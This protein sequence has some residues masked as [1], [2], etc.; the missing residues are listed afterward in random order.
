[1]KKTFVL[2][3]PI[4]LT[5][6]LVSAHT[7]AA[8]SELTQFTK[9]VGADAASQITFEPGRAT[10]TSE[11]IASLNSIVSNTRMNNSKI[12]EVKVFVWGDNIYAENKNSK[13]TSQERKVADDRITNIK[14]Y[15]SKELNVKDIETFNMARESRAFADLVPSAG[16]RVRDIAPQG[17]VNRSAS[18]NAGTTPITPKSI[19]DF[20]KGSPSEALVLIY[21]E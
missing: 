15:L 6:K 14:N 19:S 18:T 8:K 20:T 5:A 2:L 11:E 21:K 12:D 17:A 13:V 16:S 3:L 9:T 1:M 4:L 7:D 10:L